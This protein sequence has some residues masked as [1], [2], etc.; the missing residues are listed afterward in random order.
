VGGFILWLP[1]LLWWLAES[2]PSVDEVLRTP[3]PDGMAEAV[4]CEINGGATTSFGYKIYVIQKGGEVPRDGHVAFLYGAVRSERAYGVN[5]QWE[6]PDA[7][8]VEY[9]RAQS[10][11][12][13]ANSVRVL[14]RS[15]A[16]KLRSGVEDSSAPAGGM[17]YNLK[18]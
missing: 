16:I 17:L 4:L 10:A 7:L 6:A 3:S 14:D 11:E 18:K 1:S 8:V 12:L 2:G 5:L 15:V 9:L 13:A